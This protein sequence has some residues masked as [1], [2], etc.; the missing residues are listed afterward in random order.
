MAVCHKIGIPADFMA[1]SFVCDKTP[2]K[3][4]VTAPSMAQVVFMV[5]VIFSY[6]EGGQVGGKAFLMAGADKFMVFFDN[7]LHIA[8]N[9]AKG[10]EAYPH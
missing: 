9:R 7:I 1:W 10:G 4:L 2:A 5:R 6:F 8:D 3:A